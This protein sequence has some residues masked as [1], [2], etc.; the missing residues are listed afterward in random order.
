MFFF[1][2]GGTKVPSISIQINLL[3]LAAAKPLKELSNYRSCWKLKALLNFNSQ[4]NSCR[5]IETTE[6]NK[7][8]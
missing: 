6:A 8:N 2:R 5:E 1:E 3:N 7:K 4:G